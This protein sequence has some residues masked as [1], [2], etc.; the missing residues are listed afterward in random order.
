MATAAVALGV[1][2]LG[3]VV[4]APA[5]AVRP[6]ATTGAAADVTATSATLTATVRPRGTGRWFFQYGG[7]RLYGATT[8]ETPAAP[9]PQRVT[10]AIAGLA[11]ATTYHFRVVAINAD[12][13]RTGADR[14]FRT[15][16]QPLTLSLA[17]APNP[18]LPVPVT[19]QYRVAVVARPEVVSPVV[20]L[21]VVVKVRAAVAR[22]RISPGLVRATFRGVI[23]PRRI[24]H[25]VEI[26]RRTP[27]GWQVVA[28]TRAKRRDATSSR[29]V[30]TVRVR[31]G[32]R[33]RVAVVSDGDYLTHAS[34]SVRI[35][36]RR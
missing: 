33:F 30:R 27:A 23:H 13:I 31:H 32:G 2:V 5:E 21:G 14:T 9:G 25:R 24:G 36:V 7:N 12:G 6:D 19:T 18:V 26:Q 11:P 35:R 4:A 29:F 16:P 28:R 10:A 34:R 15:L 22:K 17:A 3:A 20:W 8:A 1:G